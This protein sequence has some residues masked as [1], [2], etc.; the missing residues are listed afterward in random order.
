MSPTPIATSVPKRALVREIRRVFPEESIR[1][2]LHIGPRTSLV[3]RLHD[4]TKIELLRLLTSTPEGEEALS[5]LERN[6]V[7]SSPPTLYLVKL[8]ARPGADELITKTTYL[9]HA[10][11]DV[12]MELG[13]RRAVRAVYFASPA[14]RLAFN[15]DAT[16]VP[17]YYEH[18]F[19]YTE[20]DPDSDDYGERKVLYSLERAFIWLVDGYSHAVIC[21]PHFVAVRPVVDFGMSHLDFS[22][23]LP[24]LTEDMLNRLAAS[25]EPRS[26]TFSAPSGELA[27]FLDVRTVTI[28]DP[29]LGE[30][31]GFTQIRQD[32]N[33][34]QTAGYYTKHPDLALAGLGIARRYG[35]VWTPARLS[36]R[37]LVTL[38]IALIDKTEEELSRQYGR[39]L[40]GYVHYFRNIVVAING[41]EVRGSV[42]EAFD[43]LVIAVLRTHAEESKESTVEPDLLHLLVRHQYQLGLTVLPDF[44]CPLC[45]DVVIGRCPDCRLP[46]TARMDGSTLVFECP[47][48]HCMQT[49]DADAGFR[50]DC[51][52]E[53]PLAAPE[54]HLTI[55][56]KPEFVAGMRQFLDAMDDVTWEG[57]FYITGY[58]LK[59][60]P[61]P[62]PPSREM[63]R[64]DDLRSWRIRA[65]HNVRHLPD[66][67]RREALLDVLR[68]TKEKCRANDGHPTHEICRNCLD[69]QI[70]AEQVETG[71]ICLPRMLGLAI[72]RDFDGVHHR[73]EIA[74][75]KYQD[76]LDDT[77]EQVRLG[78]HLKSRTKPRPQG[79]GHSVPQVKALYTQLFYSAYLALTGRAEFDVIGISI[80]N[81]ILE[82]VVASL[83]HLV[84]ELGFPLLVVDEGDW[85][86]IV[87]AVMEQFEVQ[88]EVEASTTE[89]QIV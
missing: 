59:V 2:W 39:D 27:T 62:H 60:V 63:V 12:A 11:R 26:A 53:V 82:E 8:Q 24:D 21:A 66:G 31:N 69:S 15:R 75:V 40:E 20:C 38:A 48:R 47:N 16:E 25:A 43:D 45:N 50:C 70:S 14:H 89:V 73:Y 44:E 86:K 81:T 9:A 71:G 80:P 22:W 87:D 5:K 28:S 42:R 46:Y 6:Y 19:E 49:P 83:R 7:L 65:R 29:D 23:A 68:L 72:S 30:R 3:Q 79:L 57:L 64:L 88:G 61:S 55:L 13:D 51:G 17:L 84:N 76:V 37:S 52:E 74:D 67:R 36:R 18:R 33:R 34:Q 35:R 58:V 1:A 77:D 32:P 78:L 10:G 4:F 41:R 56:P 85:V 54:N